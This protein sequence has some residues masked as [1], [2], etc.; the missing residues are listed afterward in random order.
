MVVGVGV[1][2]GRAGGGEVFVLLVR[3]S[4]AKNMRRTCIIQR[5]EERG[6]P[7]TQTATKKRKKNVLQKK[8]MQI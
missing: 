1:G 5:A 6:S 3:C 4:D 8:C 2:V 7:G